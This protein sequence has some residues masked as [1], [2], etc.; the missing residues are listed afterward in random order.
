MNRLVSYQWSV[1]RKRCSRDG[2]VSEGEENGRSR[3]VD[4]FVL[5][6][7]SYLF[8]NC[9]TLVRVTVFFS[10]VVFGKCLCVL[11]MDTKSVSSV[12]SKRIEK[13]NSKNRT[14]CSAY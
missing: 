8:S 6:Y 5:A 13:E 4:I 14:E 10:S 9:P 1:T 11:R 12:F 7:S 2:M 3:F